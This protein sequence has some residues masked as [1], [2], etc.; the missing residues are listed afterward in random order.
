MN[1]LKKIMEK[2]NKILVAVYGSLRSDM[3]NHDLLKTSEYL[4]EFKTE[5][6]FSLYSLGGYPGLKEG[7]NT[8][9]VMEVY[10]VDET[11]A[12]RVDQLEG[13]EEG[14]PATFYDKI[15]IET[16]YGTAGVYTYVNPI[17]EDRL[18]ESG[19]WKEH[20]NQV[21]SHYTMN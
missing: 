7:G 17:P 20:R 15:N 13:Y 12:K 14:R 4:G 19:D 10:A 3:S 21:Y 9:V 8:S 1:N 16:P 11:V 6:V 18:V 5:P 2:E